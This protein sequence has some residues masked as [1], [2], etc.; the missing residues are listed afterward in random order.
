MKQRQA[1][2]EEAIRT[3]LAQLIR[4]EVKDPRVASTGL[5]T[6]TRVEVNVDFSVARVFVSVFG[7][8]PDRTLAGLTAAAGFLR[9]PV[10]RELRLAKP[11]DLRFFLDDS[12]T[13]TTRL[14]DVVR[15][16]EERAR[17]FAAVDKLEEG[18][19]E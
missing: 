19:G 5:I 17:Q 1:R 6:V 4:D 2:V 10:R 11:P 18:E 9:G 15:E 14:R 7:Q 12:A 16:D 3:V 8:D 13:M